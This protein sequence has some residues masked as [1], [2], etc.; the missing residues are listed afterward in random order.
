MMT[1]ASN[2]KWELDTNFIIPVS[3]A[4]FGGAHVDRAVRD[5]IEQY[6]HQLKERCG[7]EIDTKKLINAV[8][9][10]EGY[11]NAKI[12]LKALEFDIEALNEDVAPVDEQEGNGIHL[13]GRSLVV[14]G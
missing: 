14:E 7:T 9:Q 6:L 3:S 5:M 1:I 8:L 4:H 10:S 2:D 12:D 13:A 11:F